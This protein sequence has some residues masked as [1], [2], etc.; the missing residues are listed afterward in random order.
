TCQDINNDGY[1]DVIVGES[2]EFT[3]TA[4]AA[5]VI[6]GAESFSTV[7]LDVS[8]LDGTNGF[9]IQGTDAGDFAGTAVAGAG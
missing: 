5:Y 6:F 9:K 3:T 2:P 4:G 1:N 7:S 8:T